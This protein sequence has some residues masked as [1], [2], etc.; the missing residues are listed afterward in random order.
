MKN[1]SV[2][3]LAMFATTAFRLD[4]KIE[5]FD[6]LYPT[7]RLSKIELHGPAP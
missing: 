7:S 4:A 3:A 5:T 1:K 6:T 2:T